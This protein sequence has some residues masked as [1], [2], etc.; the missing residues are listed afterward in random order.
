[1]TSEQE[2]TESLP[3]VFHRHPCPAPGDEDHEAE[4]AGFQTGF[5][6]RPELVVAARIAQDAAAGVA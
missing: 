2:R 5:V 1:M 3:G 6:R 4:L